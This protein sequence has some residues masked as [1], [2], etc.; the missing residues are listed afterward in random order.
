M[1]THRERNARPRHTQ[2]KKIDFDRDLM[3]RLLNDGY[4]DPTMT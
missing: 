1:L 3:A 2:P 4:D